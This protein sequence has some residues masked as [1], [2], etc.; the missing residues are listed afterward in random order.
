MLLDGLVVIVSGVGPG[1]GQE[2]VRAALEQGASVVMACRRQIFLDELSAELEHADDRLH[3]V[4]ADVTD[5][6]QCIRL[7]TEAAERFGGIDILINSAYDSGPY[8]PFDETDFSS[9]QGPLEVNLFGALRLVQAALPHLKASAN[10]SVVNVNSMVVRKPLPNQGAYIASKGALSAASKSLAVE[11]GPY[12]V[13][14]NSVIMGWMWGDAVKRSLSVAAEARGCELADLRAEVA[15]QIPLGHIPE[16]ADCAGA[17]LFFA[18]PLS[19]AVTGA[20]LDVNGGE[21]MP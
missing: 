19:R 9:W 13:R 6:Q 8:E 3:A 18:S 7:V 11:L 15:S 14:V 20:S 5:E 2:M 12:G 16:D 10:A 17:V 1:L 21:Y 4:V